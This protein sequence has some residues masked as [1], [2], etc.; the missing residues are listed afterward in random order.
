MEFSHPDDSLSEGEDSIVEN[1]L[2]DD[3]HLEGEVA[4]NVPDSI[5]QVRRSA[6]DKHVPKRFG[7][8]IFAANN[9]ETEPVSAKEALLSP[10][11][12]HWMAAM[13]DEMNSINSNDVY[14]LVKLPEGRKASNSRWVFKKKMTSDGSVDRYKARLVAQGFSQKFG[15]DYD[16]TFCPVVRFESIRTVIALAVQNDMKLHQMDVTAAFLNGKLS[17][18]IYMKQ[19]EGFVEKGKKHLVC[20]LKK[21]IYGLK[22]SPRCWNFALDDTLKK[23]GF[24]QTSGDPCIYVNSKG[25]KFIIAIY[26]DDIILCC[27]SEKY[28]RK[29]KDSLSQQY[30]MKNLGE[31][32][33]FL[34]VKIVQDCDKG[35]VWIGQP[36]YTENILKTF[37]ME[38]AKPVQPPVDSSQ[39]LVKAT[40]TS[41]L[42]DIEQYQSAVGSL[43]YLSVKTRPDIT[44]AV[45]NVA[46]FCAKPTMQHWM[47]VKRI[48]RYL[49]GTENFWNTV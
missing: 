32:N 6:R 41:S 33:Y 44:Y 2:P 26:V 42:C 8:W 40:E 18:E 11:K 22:Q 9:N 25:E 34:G 35:Q 45:S 39:K 14:D 49:K 19:P 36:V 47:A 43:L 16:E 24:V 31:L 38:N 12:E 20:K 3:T 13:Q 1:S 23:L 30:N 7:E 15:K 37:G 4:V 17:E 10:E 27:K 21:S 5:V 29:I 28:L 48:M 46:R